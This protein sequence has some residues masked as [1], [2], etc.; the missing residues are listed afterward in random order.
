MA[1]CEE[2]ARFVTYSI[3]MSKTALKQ[4]SKI[5]RR[6]LIRL[7]EKI[8]QLSKEPVPIASSIK[9]LMKFYAY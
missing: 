9:L 6:D 2:G 8:D 4:M 1:G 7:G 3:E 5:P